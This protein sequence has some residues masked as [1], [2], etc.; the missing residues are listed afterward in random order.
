MVAAKLLDIHGD[1]ILVFKDQDMEAIE[2]VCH[3]KSSIWERMTINAVIRADRH[4]K[5]T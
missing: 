1:E 5:K 3:L 2:Q 4:L